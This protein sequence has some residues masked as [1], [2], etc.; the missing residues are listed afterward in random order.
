MSKNT[1]DGCRIGVGSGLADGYIKESDYYI[2]KKRPL[3]YS[4]W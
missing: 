1:V 3:N 4:G 2:A